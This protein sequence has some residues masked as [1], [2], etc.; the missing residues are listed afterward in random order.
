VIASTL[1]LRGPAEGVSFFRI[2]G[3]EAYP[4]Q[5]SWSPLGWMFSSLYMLGDLLLF[6]IQSRC[7]DLHLLRSLFSMSANVLTLLVDVP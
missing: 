7:P 3:Y 6:S 4:Q 2:F 1:L 5:K